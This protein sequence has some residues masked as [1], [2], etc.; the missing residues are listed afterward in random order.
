MGGETGIMP[1][2]V[3]GSIAMT[4]APRARRVVCSSPQFQN[5]FSAGSIQF[6]GIPPR[7]RF[8]R[9]EYAARGGVSSSINIDELILDGSGSGNGVG[10]QV[11]AAANARELATNDLE[12]PVP[13][14]VAGYELTAVATLTKGVFRF[15]FECEP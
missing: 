7:A 11:L 5:D 10:W 14:Y 6:L 1:V 2:T 12:H 8:V 13:A 9:F 15:V 4:E 3:V